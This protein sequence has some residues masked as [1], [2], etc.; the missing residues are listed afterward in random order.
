M[1]SQQ[2]YGPVRNP[3]ANSALFYGIVSVVLGGIT[4]A[5][6]IGFAG[7]ITGGFAIFYGITSLI[8]ANRFPHKPGR[9]QS[10]AAI[11]LGSLALLFVIV[12]FLLQ[13]AVT[14]SY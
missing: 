13:L 1:L 12:G 8:F 9:A 4:L 7:I 10:I 2:P 3:R 11:V 14:S 6:R 5:T